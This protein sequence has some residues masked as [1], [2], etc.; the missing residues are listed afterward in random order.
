MIKMPIPHRVNSI[1]P[2]AEGV[3]LLTDILKSFIQPVVLDWLKGAVSFTAVPMW[4]GDAFLRFLNHEEISKNR[5]GRTGIK[6]TANNP[7]SKNHKL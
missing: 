2:M 5:I 1:R 3:F 7:S 4:D 6:G